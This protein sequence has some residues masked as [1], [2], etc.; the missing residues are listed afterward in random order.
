MET[1]DELI[2]RIRR[3]NRT[4]EIIQCRHRPLYLRHVYKDERLPLD[5][6]KELYIGSLCGIAAPESFEDGLR[7]L[8]AKIEL[9]RHF[10]DHHRYTE[11][12]LS[13]FL[14]RCVRRDVSAVITTEKD[15]VRFP[16]VDPLEVPIYYLRVEIEILSGQETWEQCVQ[17]ICTPPIMVLP[18]DYFQ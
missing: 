15:A 7:N 2:K 9:S 13:Q 11:K 10:A 3:Y 5:Y 4:A 18:E 8:G 16:M 1:N 14:Q 12:E 17:R 6:L